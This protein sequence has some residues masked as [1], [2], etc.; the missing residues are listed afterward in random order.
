MRIAKLISLLAVAAL[1]SS[2]L[3]AQTGTSSLRGTITDPKGAV[4]PGAT[5]TLSN[6][7]TGYTRTAKTNSQGLYQFLEVLPATYKLSAQATGFATLAQDNVILMVNTPAT[8]DLQMQVAGQAVTVEVTGSAPMVNTTDASLGHAFN[9]LQIQDLPFEGRDPTGILS[10]QAGV[11]YTGNNDQAMP[12]SEDSRSGS[13]AGARSDQA[14]IT[15]DGIDNNDPVLGQAFQ[16]ALRATLDSLQEFRVTTTGGNADEGRSSGAQV[17]LVTKSGTNQFHGTLY[18]YHRPTF[19]TANDWFVKN[20]QLGSGEAN[21]PGKLIRNTFG[22]AIGGPIK[23]D[24]LFFFAT[25]EG[26]RLRE[27]TSV[28]RT[29]PSAD[30]RNGFISYITDTGSVQRLTPADLAKMDPS[31]STSLPTPGGTCPLGPGANPAVMKIFQ[32]Y[33]LPNTDIVGDG[34]NFRGYQFTAGAPA[35][36]NTYIVKLDYNLTENGNHRL[37]LRGNLQND[38]IAGLG[39]DGPEFPGA[40]PNLTHLSNNKGLSAGYTAILRDNLI[41][42]I[43]YG[44]VRE[45]LDDVGL[46]NS[47]FVN[48]RGLNDLNG[49]TSTSRVIVPMHNLVD[50]VTWTKGK[51]TFQFGGN[52][53]IINDERLGNTDSY[54]Y[55]Q[56]NVSWLAASGIA[57]SNG[58]LDPGAFGFPAVSN[59]FVQSYDLPMAALAGLV[60]FLEGEYNRNKNATLL[61]EGTYVPRHFKAHEAEWYAQDSLRVTPTL[62]VTF[63]ARYTLLQPPYEVNGNQVAPTVDLSQFFNQRGQLAQQGQA[64]NSCDPF[65]TNCTNLVGLGLSGPAN[66]KPPLWN[67][68]YGNI[69][70]RFSFAWAPSYDSGILKHITGGGAGKFSIRGGYGIY[71]DHFGEGIVNSFDRNGSFGLTTLIDNPAGTQNPDTSPRIMSPTVTSIP[72]IAAAGCAAPPCNI[73]PAAPTGPFPSIPPT[74]LSNGGFAITWGLDG[75][76]HT[77]YSHVI[78]FSITRELPKNFVVEASYVGRFAHHLLQEED[79]ATPVNMVDPKSHMDYF[80]AATML[81]KAYDAGVPIQQLKNIPYWQNLFP[82]AAGPAATQLGFASGPSSGCAPGVASMTGNVTATQA[83]YD[84]FSCERGNETSALFYADVPLGW[85]DPG[86]CFPACATINGKQTNGYAFYNP[87]W[88]SLY[89]WRS[90][91]NSA[92]NGLQLSLRKRM[93]NGLNLDVNYT[94]SKSIDM[95]SNA[96]RI[97]EFEGF[98]VGASQIINAWS[99]KQLRAV[100]DFDNTHQINANWVYELPIGRGR[101]FGSGMGSVLNALVGGWSISGLWRWSSGFPFTVEP[102][103]GFWGT[104]W[105]LTSAVVQNGPLPKTGSYNVAATPGGSVL[106]NVFQDPSTAINDFRLAYPGESG[107]RNNLRG[108][109]TFDIDASLGKVWKVAEGKDLSFRWETFNVTNTPRFDVGQMQYNGNNSLATAAV[110]GTFTNTLNKPRLM[111]FALRFTF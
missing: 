36:L 70:P 45:G 106:P 19:T 34:F 27:N 105:Q 14:N 44:F 23:K 48:F 22:G 7:Q 55:G 38:S 107:Q 20:A 15:I 104:D 5:V 40:P 56:T 16:G 87:Q 28:V 110:F 33:P 83:M 47:P 32:Q 11:A 82:G 97:N 84:L 72:T 88:S 46:Q 95:G 67:W 76:M 91:G 101:H 12:Q 13:V 108:P 61:P 25:Y 109:G 85:S 59:D 111:E 77:P 63:G 21:I 26:Q 3:C 71:Y 75:H 98:G 62:T 39:N 102:G 9:A 24:R 80:T 94:Y 17:V 4:I 57:G 35:K 41:N 78:N 43:R 90:I 8:L 64:Y 50:D 99:P 42:N 30:L 65:A 100:S 93:S 68:D 52:I 73:L 37:F 103:L 53:R 18:E 69:A 29:V 58:S 49:E 66:G 60:P 6:P 89:A 81:A 31:C 54:N 86:G 2:Y 96:E 74:D 51:H 92:Y 79:L 1:V 10:L